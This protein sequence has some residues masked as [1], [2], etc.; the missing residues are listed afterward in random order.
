M[1]QLIES[2]VRFSKEEEEAFR[3]FARHK[4]LKKKLIA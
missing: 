2:G 1:D 4:L 3:F